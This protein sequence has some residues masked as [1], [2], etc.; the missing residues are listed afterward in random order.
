MRAV[1]KDQI[2]K[3]V[4]NELMP[5][6]AEF[7]VDPV[8]GGFLNSI[9]CEGQNLNSAGDKGL[10][11]HARFLW[12]F[13]RAYEVLKKE[14]YLKLAEHAFSYLKKH[15]LDSEFGGFYYHVDSE[16]SA[17]DTR[18]HVYAQAF[19][20]YGL[21]HFAQVTE[22]PEAL[23]LAN[24]LSD[25]LEVKSKDSKF[26]G[27]VECFDRKWAP[28][29]QMKE[30]GA[31]D[32]EKTMNTHIHLLEAYSAYTK[33]NSKGMPALNH[34]TDIILDKI[35]LSER[36]TLG[37]YF[38]PDWKESRGASSFGH[39]IELSWL[40]KEA[41]ELSA[42]RTTDVDLCSAQLVEQVNR[43]GMQ[44]FCLNKPDDKRSIWW[45]QAEALVGFAHAR[46]WS[47]V[48]KIWL[49]IQSH[50]ILDSGEWSENADDKNAPVG[51]L[52]KTCYHNLRACLEVLEM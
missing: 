12:S 28:E 10:V 24:D 38:S 11:Q 9:G 49:W 31:V 44:E 19:T 1:V 46:K 47:E 22:N 29:K 32:Y 23:T 45:V 43:E 34:L 6:W 35:Y 40:L 41:S 7:A 13:S 50:H 15:F 18:K 21:S 2:R 52:W 4:E 27:Y 26:G 33:I 16:G 36:S 30:Y 48:E 17:T 8:H 25:L 51:H 37:L 3:H 39:D 42:H 5:F 20:L 14:I